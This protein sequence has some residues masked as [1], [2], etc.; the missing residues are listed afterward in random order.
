MYDGQWQ[1]NKMSGKGKLYYQSGALAFDGDWK[2]DQ[3]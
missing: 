1:H 3:F 2:N